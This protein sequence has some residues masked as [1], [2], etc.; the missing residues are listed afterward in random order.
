VLGKALRAELLD[1]AGRPV[2]VSNRGIA[3]ADPSRL[4][5]A[6]DP[7]S[8]VTG[9]AGPWPCDERWWSKRG[10]SRKARMQVLTAGGAAYLLTCRDGWW[11]EG[12]YD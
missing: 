2:G 8:E 1:A 7:W 6:G 9:W 5:V 11:V 12:I 4:S 3:S 10:R